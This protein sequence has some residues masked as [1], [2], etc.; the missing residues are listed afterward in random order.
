MVHH[1]LWCS[2]HEDLK[3][4]CVAPDV[5]LQWVTPNKFLKKRVRSFLGGRST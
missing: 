2:F 4:K 1:L 5:K 3:V